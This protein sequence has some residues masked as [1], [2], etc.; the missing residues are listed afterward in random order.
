MNKKQLIKKILKTVEEE[1]E[2]S[3]LDQFE[4]F[5]IDEETSH[6]GNVKI[7]C[8]DTLNGDIENGCRFTFNWFN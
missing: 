2:M 6:M 7:K 5:K 4:D 3:I 1:L 8:K